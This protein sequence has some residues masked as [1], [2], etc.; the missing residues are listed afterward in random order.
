[1][2]KKMLRLKQLFILEMTLFSV[3]LMADNPLI[4]EIPTI[5]EDNEDPSE[6]PLDLVV[7]LNTSTGQISVETY[8]NQWLWV[9]IINANTGGVYSVD[10]IDTTQNNGS[11][12]YTYAPS[13]P[14][15]YCILFQSASA[16]AYGY[17]TII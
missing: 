7:Y 11:I 17:F 9:Y 13:L 5:T 4:V 3:P 6:D 14:G 15:N 2:K 10:F 8:V 16:E 12:Y 1:M